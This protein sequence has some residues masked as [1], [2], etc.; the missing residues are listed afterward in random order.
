MARQGR[1]GGLSRVGRAPAPAGATP[2]GIDPARAEVVVAT[3]RNPRALL[4]CLL[5]LAR[6]TAPG[7]A[8]CIA[9]DAEDPDT[10]AAVAQAL[11]AAPA[12]GPRLRHLTQPDAGFRKNRILNAAIAGSGADYLVF[13]DGDCLAH[14]GFVARHCAVARPDR[15]MVGGVVR[16]SQAAT[17]SVTAEDVLSGRVFG[18]EWLSA[19]GLWGRLKHRIKLLP[20]PVATMAWLD[21]LMPARQR[22]LGGNASTF[23][24]NLIRVNGFDESLGYGAEDKELGVRLENAGVRPFQIRYTAPLLHLEHGRGYVET[25]RND[26]NLA[27]IREL[28]RTRRSWTPHGLAR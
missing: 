19:A 14:P 18:R 23:R 2:G 26:A 27:L 4:L 15:Y 25:R 20:R 21:R 6:Q 5:A 12:L 24:Q 13:L 8:V 28:R 11:A 22:W 9:E 3:Y 16:L 1:G 17:D 7:F 10:A